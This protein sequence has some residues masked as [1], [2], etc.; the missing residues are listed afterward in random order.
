MTEI[1]N[2]K[3]TKTSLDIERMFT[4]WIHL[5]YSGAG[6]AFGGY[7]LGGEWGCQFIRKVLET[8]GV[9][10]WENLP[11][12]YIRVECEH[13]KVHRIGHITDDKWFDPQND[14]KK[15]LPINFPSTKVTN[16]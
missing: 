3:I 8:V 5:D 12:K 15:Y 14:L 13:S 9:E 4:A 16:E 10:C 7:C 11:G 1:R 6:Q 2:A